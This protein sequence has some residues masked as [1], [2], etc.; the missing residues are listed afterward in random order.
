MNPAAAASG[1]LWRRLVR[2][3]PLSRG[4]RARWLEGAAV[5]AVDPAT[6]RVSLAIY[7]PAVSA[8]LSPSYRSLLERQLARRLKQRVVLECTPS[9]ATP[10]TRGAPST[11]AGPAG[12][13][14]SGA[15]PSCDPWQR[16]L[17]HLERTPAPGGAP[18]ASLRLCLASS[19]LLGREGNT[20]VVGLAS[21]L[22][23]RLA[24]TR[25][26]SAIATALRQVCGQEAGVRFVLMP[27]PQTA[28]EG[29]ER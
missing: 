3:L 14:I 11:G 24:T 26:G 27:P 25:F 1:A 7:D 12:V 19:R 15:D 2:A 21:R 9:P 29:A 22:A 4:D 23:M 10:A 6:G 5:T 8:K 13:T 28:S 18:P 17:A 20:L 16:L